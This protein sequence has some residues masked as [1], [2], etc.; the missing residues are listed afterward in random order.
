M[1]YYPQKEQTTE[2]YN[3]DKSQ[4]YYAEQ[5]ILKIREHILFDSTYMKF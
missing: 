3:T 2:T 5:K 1:E 4:K